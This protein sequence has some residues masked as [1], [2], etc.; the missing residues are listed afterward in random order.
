MVRR[1]IYQPQQAT[2]RLGLAITDPALILGIPYRPICVSSEV[3]ARAFCRIAITAALRSLTF[4][5]VVGWI[6]RLAIQAAVPALANLC[7]KGIAKAGKSAF[8]FRGKDYDVK[9][10][11]SLTT[12]KDRGDREKSDKADEKDSH[13]DLKDNGPV[14]RAALRPKSE[15]STRIIHG[16]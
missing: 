15:T 7:A 16:A 9:L 5:P 14:K 6:I 10:D 2:G 11:K 3:A 8:K 12:K 4:I 13:C 1:E